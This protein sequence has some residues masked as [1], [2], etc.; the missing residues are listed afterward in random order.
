MKRS[1]K[2]P[3]PRNL[4]AW[5]SIRVLVVG[6]LCW[7]VVQLARMARAGT[8]P[9]PPA[10]E[11]FFLLLFAAAAIWI[12][13]STYRVWRRQSRKEPEPPPGS[14]GEDGSDGGSHH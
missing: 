5:V 9:V 3:E 13:V 14:S 2:R 12:T 1:Q 11:W 10:A 8:S 4:R 7:L 6:Y